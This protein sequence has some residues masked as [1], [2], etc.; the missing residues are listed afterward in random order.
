MSIFSRTEI[1][2]GDEA[3]ERLKNAR[4][5]VFGVGGVGDMFARCLR[6]RVWGI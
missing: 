6:A 4:V 5:A 1:L 3:M 2:L